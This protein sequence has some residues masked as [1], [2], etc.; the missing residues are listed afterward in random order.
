MHFIKF[1]SEL[2]ALDSVCFTPQDTGDGRMLHAACTS[3]DTQKIWGFFF[4][5]WVG[6]LLTV[7]ESQF[8]RTYLNSRSVGGMSKVQKKAVKCFTDNGQGST[9]VWGSGSLGR[10]VTL[11]WPEDSPVQGDLLGEVNCFL[12]VSEELA[13][14]LL[15]AA[16]LLVMLGCVK[17]AIIACV[18]ARSQRRQANDGCF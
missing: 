1:V 18:V 13:L 5:F 10:M 17:E 8:W 12:F 11:S 2:P 16:V 6:A 9:E 15:C 7:S 4:F 14:Q 3:C